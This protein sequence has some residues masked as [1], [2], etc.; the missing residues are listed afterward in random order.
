MNI[1]INAKI[2]FVSK[3]KL[4][5][6]ISAV[7]VAASIILFLVV[8][9][10]Y[11]VDFA[12]G[13]EIQFKAEGLSTEELRKHLSDFGNMDIQEFEGKNNEFLV[14]F[15]NISMV[16]DETIN[17]YIEGVKNKFSDSK[18]TKQYFD[19][20]VGD[21]IEMWFDKP[22]DEA[23][24]KS[25]TE[26]FKI[27]ATGTIEYKQVG[28]RHIY[29]VLLEG[30][31]TEILSTIKAKSGKE[32]ELQRVELVGPKVGEKLRYSALQS[33]FYA[34][35][36]ILIYVA[37][38]FNFQ[39]APGAVISLFHD[40]MITVGIWSLFRIPFDLTI[41]AAL[42]TIVGY[43]INDTIVIYDRI[44]ENWD[45]PK[46]GKTLAE[47]MN[48]SLNETLTRTIL[49]AFTTLMAVLALL[50]FGGETIRG[51]ALAMTFGLVAGSYSTLFIASPITLLVEKWMNKE[52]TTSS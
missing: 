42:L 46:K 29:K 34:L 22:V 32:P 44:R 35:I 3:F 52:K 25:L 43:S 14:R 17:K 38:R 16:N 30:L 50:F 40:V 23:E 31:T 15:L 2:D 4:C 12:G 26:Q 39:F 20:Q 36:A 27:P 10:N 9:L 49:T 47:K 1:F 13:T 6:I 51:F 8:G 24:L 7:M 37:F 19:S 48:V 28:D 11:G 21:R 18:L 45:N 33:I 5:G 41:V